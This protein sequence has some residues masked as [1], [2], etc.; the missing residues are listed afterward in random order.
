MSFVA[1]KRILA[2][3][4]DSPAAIKLSNWE[5]EAQI[6]KDPL[7]RPKP[8]LHVFSHLTKSGFHGIPIDYP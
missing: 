6:D 8:N 1:D 3:S 2:G 4:F 5:I 7:L